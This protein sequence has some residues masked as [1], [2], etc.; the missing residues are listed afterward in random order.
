MNSF[1]NI[2]QIGISATRFLLRFMDDRKLHA[3]NKEYIIDLLKITSESLSDIYIGSGLEKCRSLNIERAKI[4][5]GDTELPKE[6]SIRAIE[7]GET[8]RY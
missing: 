2:K 8:Y 4:L 1:L 6:I 7:I 3:K 5:N